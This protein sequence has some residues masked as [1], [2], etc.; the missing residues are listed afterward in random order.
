DRDRDDRVAVVVPQRLAEPVRADVVG[1][2][3]DLAAQRATRGPGAQGRD[4]ADTPY[5]R[6]G[7]VGHGA[8]VDVHLAHAVL[9]RQGGQ[10]GGA[11]VVGD[12]EGVV[13]LVDEDAAAGPAE[14]DGAR[15]VVDL[16]HGRAVVD[17]DTRLGQ[18][19]LE[20]AVGEG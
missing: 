18:G 9:L 19:E 5:P 15:R 11:A 3:L 8:G 6:R 12:D 1:E 10:P 17:G 7:A 13:D 16:G 14:G 2:D 20:A 4:V